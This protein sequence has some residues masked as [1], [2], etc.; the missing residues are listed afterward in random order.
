MRR[1]RPAKPEGGV[2][3]DVDLDADVDEEEV[4]WVLLL[5]FHS[6]KSI[7]AQNARPWPVMMP[8]RRHGSAS[9]Q[10]HSRCSSQWPCEGIE[11][12]ARGRERVTRRT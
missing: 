1:E 10:S 6:F 2:L 3:R 4:V 9:N 12:R 7:P 5:S 8:T 11:L